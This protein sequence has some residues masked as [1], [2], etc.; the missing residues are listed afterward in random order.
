[1]PKPTTTSSE[2]QR[3]HAQRAT[4]IFIPSNWISRRLKGTVHYAMALVSHSKFALCS[5]NMLPCNIFCYYFLFAWLCRDDCFAHAVNSSVLASLS[6]IAVP[7]GDPDHNRVLD[8]RVPP[9]ILS[10]SGTKDGINAY[11]DKIMTFHNYPDL[12]G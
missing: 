12:I 7:F 5:Y 1:V 6:P 10:R 2:L 11:V 9:R 8:Q 3:L 4:P